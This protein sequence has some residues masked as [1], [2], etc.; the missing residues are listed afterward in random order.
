MAKADGLDFD[1]VC[2]REA[3]PDLDE[4]DSGSCVAAYSE[5]HDAE[6]CRGWYLRYARAAAPALMEEGARLALEA[7]AGYLDGR[8]GIVIPGTVAFAPLVSGNNQPCMSGN[9]ADRLHPPQRRK[10]DDATATLAEAIRALDPAVIVKGS[11]R[12]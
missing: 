5:D 9:P 8:G 3:D 4:C 12:E 7:A 1:E 11:G 6:E 10:F 2:G